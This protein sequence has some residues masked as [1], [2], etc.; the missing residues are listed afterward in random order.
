MIG[1]INATNIL[2]LVSF[3]LIGLLIFI[4]AVQIFARQ[5]LATVP[6]WSGEEAA[7]FLLMWSICIG[8][9]LAAGRNSHL[10]VDYFIDRFSVKKQRIIE[11]FIYLIISVFLLIIMMVNFQLAWDGRFAT[12]PRLNLSTFWFQVSI[13]ASAFIM[14]YFYIKHLVNTIKLIKNNFSIKKEGRD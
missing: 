12:T 3:I 14:L 1:R 13:S 8:A 5:F 7:N 9:G 6:A 10:A 11:V 4:M 2:G